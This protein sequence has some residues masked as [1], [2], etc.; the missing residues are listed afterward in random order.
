MNNLFLVQCTLLYM[1]IVLNQYKIAELLQ[2]VL[3]FGSCSGFVVSTLE[4]GSSGPGSSP[5]QGHCVVF[6]GKAL[7]SDGASLQPG[8]YTVNGYWQT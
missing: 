6:L 2:I 3:V 7:Y 8:V 5:G 1:Y 4:S